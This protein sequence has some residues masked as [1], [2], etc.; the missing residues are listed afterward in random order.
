MIKNFNNWI[1]IKS[2]VYKFDWL[3]LILALDTK[4]FY[5]FFVEKDIS[6]Y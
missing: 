3:I 1:L 2:A 4:Y 6:N 5:K